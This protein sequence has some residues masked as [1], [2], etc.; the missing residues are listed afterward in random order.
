MDVKFVTTL[1]RLVDTVPINDGQ[2]ISTKDGSDLFY[3]MGNKRHRIGPELW[4]PIVDDT[5]TP[6][7]TLTDANIGIIQLVPNGGQDVM[8]QPKLNIPNY[9]VGTA[10]TDTELSR[11]P[12]IS[13]D[14]YKFNGWYEDE[15]TSGNR[16]ETFPVK[17]QKGK[18]IYYASW[19]KL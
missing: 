13:R 12:V 15:G 10:G 14:G 17:F 9:V 11:I 7:F 3:D 2:V 5:I 1:K 4:H 18:T 16:V 6:G 19:I 8:L